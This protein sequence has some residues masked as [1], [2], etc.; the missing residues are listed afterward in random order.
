MNLYRKVFNRFLLNLMV[1]Y[2]SLLKLCDEN[3][4]CNQYL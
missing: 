4:Y 3:D 2:L 1:S